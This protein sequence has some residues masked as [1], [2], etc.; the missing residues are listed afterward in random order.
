MIIKMYEQ[1]WLDII[2]YKNLKVLKQ[3]YKNL[4]TGINICNKTER[5]NTIFASIYIDLYTALD[6]LTKKQH[7]CMLEYYIKGYTLKEIAFVLQVTEQ[8]IEKHIN[9]AIKKISKHL[10]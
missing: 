10:G 2:N 7:Y 1:L 8:N 5:G 6:I 3:L 4:H 9:S